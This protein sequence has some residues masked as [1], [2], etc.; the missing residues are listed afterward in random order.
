M[1]KISSE[2][3]VSCS[4]KFSDTLKA[5]EKQFLDDPGG[6][7][8]N[9]GVLCGGIDAYKELFERSGLGSRAAVDD[10]VG[11]AGRQVQEDAEDLLQAEQ[12]WEKFLKKVETHV[13]QS[14]SSGPLLKVGDTL[15]MN[16]SLTLLGEDSPTTLEAV[17]E[18]NTIKG[19]RYTHF[20]LNRF[21]G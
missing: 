8:D 1:A 20:V 17:L 19:A 21:Y 18:A 7:V 16:I 13:Q 6:F 10:A 12:D 5:A 3:I 15:P 9:I 14:S 4:T 2:L 11:R